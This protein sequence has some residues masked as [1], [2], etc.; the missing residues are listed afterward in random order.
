M[1]IN[2]QLK[3]KKVIPLEPRYSNGLIGCALDV[4]REARL[5]NVQSMVISYTRVEDG[6]SRVYTTWKKDVGTA[7]DALMNAK[8]CEEDVMECIRRQW[9]PAMPW[10]EG[11]DDG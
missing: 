3:N 4:M 7:A 11:D 6:T 1:E 10:L 8:M 5:G 2:E 9:S